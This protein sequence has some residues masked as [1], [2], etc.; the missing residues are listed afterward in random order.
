M[1]KILNEGLEKIKLDSN[2]IANVNSNEYEMTNIL[3]KNP[4]KLLHQ[5]I[6]KIPKKI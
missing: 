4:E 6:M 5:L 3:K 1:E 2:A